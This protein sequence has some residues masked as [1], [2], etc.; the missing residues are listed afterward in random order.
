MAIKP[1]GE[2]HVVMIGDRFGQYGATK[3][4]STSFGERGSVS[5]QKYRY[6]I[7]I[8]GQ[9]VNDS[10]DAMEIAYFTVALVVLQT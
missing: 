8:I 10:C 7:N 2:K 1:S 3:I 4:Q 9:H 6:L 5:S